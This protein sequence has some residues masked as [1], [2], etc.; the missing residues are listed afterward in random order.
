MAAPGHLTDPLDES[1]AAAERVDPSGAPPRNVCG[2][3]AVAP[4]MSS[5]HTVTI[6]PSDL[7][8][9]VRLDGELLLLRGESPE[10]ALK[11]FRQSQARAR[12]QAAHALE[13]RA[14]ISLARCERQFSPD[15]TARTGLSAV[16]ASFTEGQDSP[17]VQAARSIL[18]T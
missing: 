1:R 8:V 12:E 13:L 16:L 2:G 6:T 18:D 3:R 17:D 14:A 10:S 7:H 4:T 11:C 15:G 5:G 9:E